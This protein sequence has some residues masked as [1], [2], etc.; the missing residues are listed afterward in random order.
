MAGII[1]VLRPKANA[2]RSLRRRR[3]LRLAE[4]HGAKPA[5]A[6]IRPSHQITRKNN[7]RNDSRA[8]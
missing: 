8:W 3:L 7:S 4:Q 2:G 5:R 1:A 6:A